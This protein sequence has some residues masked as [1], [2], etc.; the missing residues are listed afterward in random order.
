MEKPANSIISKVL[1]NLGTKQEARVVA[2]WFAT[3]EG[4]AY[5]QKRMDKE[6]QNYY[7]GEKLTFP[8]EDS[9]FQ[10]IEQKI[11]RRKQHYILL[12][13]AAV[14]IPILLFSLAAWYINAKINPFGNTT[15]TT[16]TTENG[17]RSHL[18]FQDG[19]HVYLNPKTTLKFPQQFALSK[20]VVNLNGEAYFDVAPNRSRPFIIEMKNTSIAVL[21]TAFNVYSYA[22]DD[23]IKI[24][25]DKGSIAFKTPNNKGCKLEAGQELYY[26]KTNK[27]IMVANMLNQSIREQGKD[28]LIVLKN[29]S[30][31]NVVKVL[32]RWYNKSFVIKDSLA[33]QYTYTTS[34]RNASLPK[35]LEELEK[36]TPVQFSMQNDTIFI[37]TQ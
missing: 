24:T 23:E 8:L 34:F 31:E 5:L 9:L 14:L 37:T 18:I 25:L 36:L 35:I 3:E 15:L 13:I 7:K 17:E 11:G 29:S 2:E 33:M 22:E 12:K 20:R 1:D 19:T 26:D 10:S 30:L 32:H 21:G 28:A 16:V 6:Y 4:C 27:K